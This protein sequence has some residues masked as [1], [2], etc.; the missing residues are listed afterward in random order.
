M[1]LMTKIKN[2]WNYEVLKKPKIDFDRFILSV[3]K[4]SLILGLYKATIN[5][6]EKKNKIII[7]K[8]KK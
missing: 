6:V 5:E 3:I 8:S 2:W 7:K 1:K 4:A